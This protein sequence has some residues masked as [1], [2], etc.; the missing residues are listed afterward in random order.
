[1][2]GPLVPVTP[3]AGEGSADG[4][5]HGGDLVLRLQRSHAVT[6][7]FRQL[8]QNVRG[9]CDGISGVN[10]RQTRLLA[11]R[12]Q[13][14]RQ[15][16]IAGD[17]A[18][19][20]GRNFRFG[21]AVMHRHRFGRFA[22]V[23]AGFQGA[24][25][26][27]HHALILGEFHPNPA[28]RRL[29]RTLVEPIHQTQS[30]E[31]L[32]AIGLTGAEFQIGHRR[33]IELGNRCGEQTIALERAVLQRIGGVAGLVQI[34]G[35]EGVG[36]DDKDAA[37]FEI[38]QIGFQRRR[39]H[40]DEG[41][42]EIARRMDVAAAEMNLEAGDARK[43]AGGARISAGK[44]GSVLMSLPSMAE[45]CVNCVPANCMPSPESP[46]NRIVASLTSS[47]GMG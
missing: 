30:E 36:I 38:L 27:L 7:Q 33:P 4:G 10:Q 37:R 21:H 18:I 3:S 32:A 40:G 47:T 22:V 16:L 8:M 43:G 24:R 11:R 5:A 34:A 20:A 39:V 41:I 6:L 28:Q 42:E 2:P 12:H 35:G 45:V 1:M 17:F 25:V 9:R 31:V 15:R 46:A 26:G 44:S 29:Q 14:E 13:T 23:V 19:A